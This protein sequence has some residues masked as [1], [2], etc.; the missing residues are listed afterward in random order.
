MV[1]V[2][3]Y[4][5]AVGACEL[6]PV[7]LLDTWAQN[8]V[9]RAALRDAARAQGVELDPQR[10]RDLADEDV[11]TPAVVVRRLALWPVK[12]LL[13]TVFVVLGAYAMWSVARDL[14]RR[15]EALELEAAR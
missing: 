6:I 11:A 5:I 1:T 3:R 15:V 9:R 12:K 2:N 13:R 4:A 7:P 8:Q 10:L 14:V